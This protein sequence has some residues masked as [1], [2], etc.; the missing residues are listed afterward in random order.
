LYN[1]NSQPPKNDGLCDRD[2]EK[3]VIRD[4]D[5]ES[6][7][8][9]RLEAYEKQTRPVLEFFKDSGHRVKEVDASYA[10]PDE[11]FSKICQAM[12]SNDRS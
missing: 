11:V 4:D 1:I 8:R 7:I 12:G 3:L 2:G 10:S 6:V 9:E 5:R